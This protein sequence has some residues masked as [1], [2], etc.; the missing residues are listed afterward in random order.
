MVAL[1]PVR[2]QITVESLSSQAP[3]PALGQTLGFP[4]ASASAVSA[5]RVANRVSERASLPSSVGPPDC[6][7]HLLELLHRQRLLD[8]R[9]EDALLVA[10]VALEPLAKLVQ[11]GRVRIWT[12]GQ[13]LR[14]AA[15]IDVVEQHSHDRRLVGLAVARVGRE[16]HLFLRTEVPG[17][18]PLEEI[19]EI[20]TRVR[21]RLWLCALQLQR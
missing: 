10:D 7:G 6:R 2:A 20:L 15:Q 19:E 8:Q 5:A 14:P 17:A 12:G 21:R 16:Q 4:R 1:V 11:L 13:I 9:E 3:S 18:L